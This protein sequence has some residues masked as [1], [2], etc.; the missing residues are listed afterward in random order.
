M[1]ESRVREHPQVDLHTYNSSV[2][3]VEHAC[4]THSL[5]GL[6]GQ[7]TIQAS[8]GA[9]HAPHSSSPKGNNATCMS[10]HTTH[11]SRS[12]LIFHHSL[13][14]V[15]RMPV[16]ASQTHVQKVDGAYPLDL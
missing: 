4:D 2:A 10:E 1:Q 11:S 7:E 16:E 13:S 8:P 3:E 6:T 14:T 9:W 15:S 5:A 12:L